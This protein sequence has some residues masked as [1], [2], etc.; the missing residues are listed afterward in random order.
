MALRVL[1]GSNNASSSAAAAAACARRGAAQP[2]PG[3]VSSA[4][5]LFLLALLSVL[6]TVEAK[7]CIG[8]RTSSSPDV[9]ECTRINGE[10][11]IDT[12]GDVVL[13]NLEY[14]FLSTHPGGN[15]IVQNPLTRSISCP[16]LK[17]IAQTLQIGVIIQQADDVFDQDYYDHMQRRDEF[18]SSLNHT[19]S[20]G[21]GRPGGSYGGGVQYGLYE[22]SYDPLDRRRSLQ[23]GT[24]SAN[25]ALLHIS[26]PSLEYVGNAVSITA[27]PNLLSVTFGKLRNVNGDWTLQAPASLDCLTVSSMTDSTVGGEFN[28][29]FPNVAACSGTTGYDAD[30]ISAVAC[31]LT[32]SLA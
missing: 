6:S 12:E 3:S 26:F 1:A 28:L 2:A 10:L 25:E 24:P 19:D 13:P 5:H 9:N 21:G 31:P 30:C 17:H 11:I 27:S 8:S 22:D 7:F 20:Y 15:L 18:Y 14:I 32:Q 16:K 4:A 29:Y 23:A